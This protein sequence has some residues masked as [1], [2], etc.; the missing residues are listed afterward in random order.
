MLTIKNVKAH[1]KKCNKFGKRYNW[2]GFVENRDL[3]PEV[4]NLFKFVSPSGHIGYDWV[5]GNTKLADL[6][7]A[8]S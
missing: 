6:L 1:I 3:T 8:I 5:H 2:L 7:L 4:E